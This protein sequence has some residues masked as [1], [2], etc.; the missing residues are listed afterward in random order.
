MNTSWQSLLD[1]L[2]HVQKAEYRD[3]VQ[4]EDAIK[5]ITLYVVQ[6]M[7]EKLRDSGTD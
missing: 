2:V 1:E 3:D 4:R 5:E 6:S 7:L